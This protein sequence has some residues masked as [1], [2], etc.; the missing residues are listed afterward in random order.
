MHKGEFKLMF[1]LHENMQPPSFISVMAVGVPNA[2]GS[3]KITWSSRK[4]KRFDVVCQ[5]AKQMYVSTC[6]L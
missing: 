5:A 4:K 1:H 3:A 2:K 6:S